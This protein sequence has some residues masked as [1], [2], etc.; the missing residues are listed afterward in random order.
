M[1]SDTDVQETNGR[2]SASYLAAIQGCDAERRHLLA[3]VAALDAILGEFVTTLEHRVKRNG[4]PLDSAAAQPGAS[5]RTTG[6]S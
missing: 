1:G 4:D 5:E 6:K 2:R 3:K